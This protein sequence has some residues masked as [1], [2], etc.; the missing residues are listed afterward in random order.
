M[1]TTD[2]ATKYEIGVLLSEADR[3]PQMTEFLRARGAE[4]VASEE[5]KQIPLA[6]PVKKRTSAYFAPIFFSASPAAIPVIERDLRLQPDLALRFLIIANPPLQKPR[7]EERSVG[8]TPAARTPVQPA[9][10]LRRLA[11][12]GEATTEELEK[13]LKEML[14]AEGGL[15]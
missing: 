8:R 2:T 9:E 1:N 15:G 14:A 13:K 7:R 10:T 6:Y 12:H 4:D 11:D 5:G 3:L